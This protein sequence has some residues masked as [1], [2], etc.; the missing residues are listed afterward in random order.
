MEWLS[1][2]VKFWSWRHLS[3]SLPRQLLQW[4]WI[5]SNHLQVR[6]FH[7]VLVSNCKGPASLSM[8]MQVIQIGTLSIIYTIFYFYPGIHRLDYSLVLENLCNFSFH[9]WPSGDQV[10]T[11]AIDSLAS[12][13]WKESWNIKISSIIISLLYMIISLLLWGLYILN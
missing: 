3:H 13:T 11:I 1:V 4:L 10:V 9:G 5:M 8:S 7:H 2:L 12:I 6:Y